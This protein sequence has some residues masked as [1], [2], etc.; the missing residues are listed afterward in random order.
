[1]KEILDVN[2]NELNLSKDTKKWLKSRGVQTF[3]DIIC[4]QSKDVVKAGNLRD[5]NRKEL[6]FFV[7]KNGFR[8]IKEKTEEPL[9]KED[10]CVGDL[11]LPLK[12]TK[13][14]IR[15]NIIKVEELEKISYEELLTFPC[16][17]EEIVKEILSKIEKMDKVKEEP[18]EEEIIYEQLLSKKDK[19]SKK[20]R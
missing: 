19:F 10:L 11:S 13:S 12:T 18:T 15:N 5:T 1:M 14:L 17:N 3:R 7:H 2:I 4:M 20:I 16:V 8:L 6:I 9:A